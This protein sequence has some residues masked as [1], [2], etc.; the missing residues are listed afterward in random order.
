V[1]GARQIS[2]VMVRVAFVGGRGPAFVSVLFDDTRR[3][4]GLAIDQ[5]ERDG[6]FWVVVGCTREQRDQLQEFYAMLTDGPIG[7]GEGGQHPPRWPDPA[8][9]TQ[10]HLDVAVADVQTAERRV[11]G[12]GARKLA[13]FPTW[14]VYADPV[15]HPF[16]LYPEKQHAGTSKPTGRLGTLAR[17]VIDC[18]DPSALAS[19]WAAMLDMPRRVQ[20]SADR[21][22]IAR[23][24]DSLPMIALQRIPDYRPPRWPDPAYPAQMHFD[25][26]YDSRPQMERLAIQLGAAQL[27]PQGG[28][29]P[30]YAD[31]AGHPFCLCYKGE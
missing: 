10:I 18:A 31:P 22:V 27:P 28:S 30:V 8:S 29:C 17:V 16:C 12:Q 4:A 25:L 6:Q 1:A 26:G 13:E 20:D 24:D 14:R 15:G 9:P 19:F 5:D 21:I 7:Y 2:D 3:V 23:A 11:L